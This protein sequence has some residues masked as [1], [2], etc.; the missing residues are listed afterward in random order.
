[1]SSQLLF[2][3]IQSV[4]YQ[5]DLILKRVHFWQ[6]SSNR[7]G[8]C[9]NF[10]L[11]IDTHR[12][13][14]SLTLCLFLSP[15]SLFKDR[16]CKPQCVYIYAMHRRILCFGASF[17]DPFV[18]LLMRSYGRNLSLLLSNIIMYS[19]CACVCARK[20]FYLCQYIS[21]RP[22][23]FRKNNYFLLLCRHRNLHH[24]LLTFVDENR[25]KKCLF[26]KKRKILSIKLRRRKYNSDSQLVY[27]WIHLHWYL[28]A[29]F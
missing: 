18:R 20:Y 23:Q 8:V 10:Q 7:I 5:F 16:G 26:F 27:V 3:L 4:H 15:A 21:I 1:M 9:S 22:V 11:F 13:N 14:H 2:R 24:V 6:P 29:I 19:S 28:C 12:H 25:T 17:V